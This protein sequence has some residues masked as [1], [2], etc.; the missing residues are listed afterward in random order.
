[1]SKQ[2]T[3]VLVAVLGLAACANTN[4]PLEEEYVVLEPAPEPISSEPAYTGKYK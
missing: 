2:L 1:M 3:V 4:A